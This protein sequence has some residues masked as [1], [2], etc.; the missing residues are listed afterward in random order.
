MT[1]PLGDRFALELASLDLTDRVGECAGGPVL[2][3]FV[4][5]TVVDRG[6]CVPLRIEVL[7]GPPLAARHGTS[8]TSGPG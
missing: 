3:R 6:V 2:E 1:G 4:A 7:H 8:S 5:G